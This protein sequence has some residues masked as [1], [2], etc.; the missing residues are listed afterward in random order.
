MQA[1]LDYL[2]TAA[3][4][5]TDRPNVS[6]QPV[7]SIT[8]G[9]VNKRQN[10][11]GISAAATVDKLRVLQLLVDLAN[12]PAIA[13]S[14]PECYTS[15]CLNVNFGCAL[16]TDSHNSGDSWIVAIGEHAGGQLFV[17]KAADEHREEKCS[18]EHAGSQVEGVSVDVRG[19]WYR[20]EG[21]KR[22]H[23]TLPYTGHRVS[24]V[25]FCVPT[26]KCDVADLARLHHFGFQI[27][28]ILPF[29]RYQCRV[30]IDISLPSI[31]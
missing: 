11:Y 13:G 12:D 14:G 19:H 3:I 16:H 15:I 22:R 9:M 10:G 24:I 21:S 5:R 25:Y 30:C 17:E 20:F 6:D 8:L 1:L 23:M 26:D 27:P 18:I 7:Q 28:T 31:L 2:K 29:V 4:P